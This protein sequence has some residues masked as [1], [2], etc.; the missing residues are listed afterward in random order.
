MFSAS[1]GAASSIV[2]GNSVQSKREFIAPKRM[3]T[4]PSPATTAITSISKLDCT[5]T[6][7]VSLKGLVTN[8]NGAVAYGPKDGRAGGFYL[9]FDV[10]DNE[11]RLF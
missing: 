9:T 4:L 11:G 2:N 3:T 5:S 7:L 8:S 1:T 6:I 10:T